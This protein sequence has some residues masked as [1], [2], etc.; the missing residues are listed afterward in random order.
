MNAKIPS[1]HAIVFTFSLSLVFL[2]AVIGCKKDK[3]FFPATLAD[4]IAVYDILDNSAIASTHITEKIPGAMLRY[5]FVWVKSL[6]RAG[7]PTLS[8]SKNEI[9]DALPA[10]GRFS[11]RI[12]GLAVNSEY[13][14]R[15]FVE[16]GEGVVYG[17]TIT[18]TTAADYLSRLIKTLDDSLKNRGF[19]YSFIVSR[20]SEVVA[21][22]FGGF[23]SRMIEDEGEKLVTADTKM[24]IASMTKTLTAAA[25][26]KLSAEK[27]IKTTDKI[28]P[29]LPKHWIVGPNVEKIT[30]RDL[31]LHQSGIVGLNGICQNGAVGENGWYGLQLLME[32]GIK[33]EHRGQQCYQNANYGMF[34]VLIPAILGYQFSGDNYTDDYE[35]RRLYEK[36]IH[37]EVLT[38]LGVSSTEI[39]VNSSIAPTYGYDFPYSEG[40][41]GFNPGDFRNAAGGY[42]IYLSAREAAKVY[43]GLFSNS[44]TSV[45]SAAM[46]DSIITRGMGSYSAITPQGKFSYH[47]G[48]W[49][50]GASTGKAKGFRSLWMKC[51]DDITVVIFTNALR[52]GDGLF[53][54]RSDFYSDITSYVLWA[55]SGI[56]TLENGRREAVNFHKYLQDPQP[57]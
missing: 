16:T 56:N 26:L 7:P 39:L 44:N 32:Y 13:R 51:P 23:Q 4:S 50:L 17:Q 47:D 3:D 5:G 28:L 25:F 48:W 30:F 20:K 14:L 9:S 46:K 29:Y 19:G 8:D 22:R 24:Q 37:E 42:G 54:I 45:L 11:G 21:E 6:E 49:Q 34:R 12:F 53:P 36:Y 2:F 35:T 10:D 27:G 55:F 43:S 38:K 41:K 40:T 33:A 1:I 52:H 57:H 15:A 31:M 18:F